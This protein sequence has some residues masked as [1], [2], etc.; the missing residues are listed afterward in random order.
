[1]SLETNNKHLLLPKIYPNEMFQS[2][3]VMQSVDLNNYNY[4]GVTSYNDASDV[5]VA[6]RWLKL[7]LN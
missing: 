6:A 7:L 1:M 3:G 5:K 2:R 4:I